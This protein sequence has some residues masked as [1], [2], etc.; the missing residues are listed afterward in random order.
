MKMKSMLATFA[1]LSIF[2]ACEKKDEIKKDCSVSTANVAGTYKIS[3]LKYKA[4]ANVPEQDFLG[5]L[6]ACE[7]DDLI[8]LNSN[9]TYVYTDAGVACSPSG[10]N[11][12]TWSISGN[13]I[14]SDGLVNGKIKSFDCKLLVF[15]VD[16]AIVQGDQLTYTLTMQ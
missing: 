9:G 6:E 10:S 1:L 16:N 15:E 14:Q 3:S 13:T 11:N 8:R 5:F 12:G 7:K 4:S 2:S